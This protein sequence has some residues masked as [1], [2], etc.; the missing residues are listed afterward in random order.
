MCTDRYTLERNRQLGR[1]ETTEGL[2]AVS[3]LFQRFKTQVPKD[4]RER[5]ELKDGDKMV[6]VHEGGMIYVGSARQI[7]LK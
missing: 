5:L 7:S 4:V 1:Y 3:T 6:W 2:L